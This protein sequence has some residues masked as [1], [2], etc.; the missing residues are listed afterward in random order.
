MRFAFLALFLLAAAL[1]WRSTTRH[2]A[3]P[4][5]AFATAMVIALV[6]MVL[7]AL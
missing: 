1:C 4:A 7:A 2:E 6:A 5:L 3:W